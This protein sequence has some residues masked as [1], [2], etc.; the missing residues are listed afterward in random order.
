MRKYTPLP[1]V[2]D[3]YDL[4]VLDASTGILTWKVRP[5][6]KRWSAKNAGK[7]AGTLTNGYVLVGIN[8][9]RFYAHRIIFKMHYGYEVDEID[10]DDRN[11]SNNRPSNLKRADNGENAKNRPKSTRNTS[12]HTGITPLGKRWLV[13]L[14]GKHIGVYDTIPDALQARVNAEQKQGYHKNHGR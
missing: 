5:H 6:D 4:F 3:L 2:N 9:K 10:H 1:S 11:R 7:P 8:K 14:S 13:K 12:G